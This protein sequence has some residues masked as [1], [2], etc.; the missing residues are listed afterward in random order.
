MAPPGGTSL[1]KK[2]KGQSP[3]RPVYLALRH[4]PQY[5]DC[6]TVDPPMFTLPLPPS[7]EFLM[8]RQSTSSTNSSFSSSDSGESHSAETAHEVPVAQPKHKSS[9]QPVKPAN[10][11]AKRSKTKKG[12]TQAKQGRPKVG[13]HA[14]P[15]PAK[16]RRPTKRVERMPP[17]LSDKQL[18]QREIRRRRELTQPASVPM[19][20]PRKAVVRRTAPRAAP[21]DARDATT[22][23]LLG[24]SPQ[25]ATKS[26]T[27]THAAAAC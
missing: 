20:S 17:P 18:V 5:G 27:Y 8:K 3:A 1:A 21:L 2:K 15:P 9:S 7:K 16:V 23:E 6:S 14:L 24:L 11:R 13:G 26:L 10:N 19:V 22:A 25:Q 12:T 4:L